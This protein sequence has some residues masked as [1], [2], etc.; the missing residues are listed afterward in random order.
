MS[1]RMG[2]DTV[3]HTMAY[4]DEQIAT[5]QAQLDGIREAAR[6]VKEARG[7]VV[8]VVCYDSSDEDTFLEAI[9]ELSAHIEGK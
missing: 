7:P 1:D 2:T 4:K 9:D 5:L 6:K 3:L 8:D